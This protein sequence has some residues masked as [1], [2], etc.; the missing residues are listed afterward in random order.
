MNNPIHVLI[1][2]DSE[3]DKDLILLE[4]KRG[5][6]N[7]KYLCV[8]TAEELNK[9]L[10]KQEWDIIL[11]D[12]SLPVFDGIEAL[13]IV[14]DSGLETPFILISGTV[15]EDVA[16][17]AMHSGAEDY[18]MK[19]N[20]RR[21]VPAIIRE[22]R[23]A[24]V[25]RERRNA[26]EALKQSEIKFKKLFNDDL[27]GNFIVSTDGT[28]LLANPSLAKIFGFN[29]VDELMEVNFKNF[30]KNQDDRDAFL[31]LLKEKKQ[32]SLYEAE[33]IRSDGKTISVIKNVTGE[34]DQ[35]GNLIG[36][37]GYLI[38]NTEQKKQKAI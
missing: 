1:I 5:G 7:P 38:D 26:N 32:I 23:E 20:L 27:T 19:G 11:S 6:F 4:L 14:K 35:K 15:G 28:I 16:V 24:E 9:A 34:F 13:R 29:S 10:K 33:H 12:Y 18:I 37:R 30:Y 22:L 8:Q 17:S 36:M 21:L 25:R 3:N 2:E 31:D